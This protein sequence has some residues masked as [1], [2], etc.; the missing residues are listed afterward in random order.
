MS[1]TKRS[2]GVELKV[3]SAPDTAAA[4]TNMIF[5]HPDDYKL[6]ELPEGLSTAPLRNYVKV[7]RFLYC[8]KYPLNLFS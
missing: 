5:A 7:K 6:L 1:G 3:V 8:V 2:S 4:L